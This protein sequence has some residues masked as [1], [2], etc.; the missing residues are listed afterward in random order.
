MDGWMDGFVLSPLPPPPPLFPPFDRFLR[1]MLVGRRR[2]LCVWSVGGKGEEEGGSVV[3]D[4]ER[5]LLVRVAA[6]VG[7]GCS[8]L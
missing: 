6:G 3:L 1:A 8:L 5:G 2:L 7:N 4:R